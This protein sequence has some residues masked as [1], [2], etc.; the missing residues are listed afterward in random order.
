[1]I[2]AELKGIGTTHFDIESIS[3]DNFYFIFTLDLYIGIK[4]GEGYDNFTLLVT[5][6]EWYMKNQKRPELIRHTLL[7]RC[8]DIDEIK[9]TII[10]YIDI[11]EGETWDAVVVKLSRMFA[12]EFEDYVPFEQG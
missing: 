5:T 9:K 4:G 12:W 6:P 3:L 7:V 10:D 1:M 8:L 11:C 2:K